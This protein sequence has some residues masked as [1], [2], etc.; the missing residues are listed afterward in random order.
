MNQ[1]DYDPDDIANAPGTGEFRSISGPI[2]LWKVESIGQTISEELETIQKNT[3]Y[4]LSDKIGLIRTRLAHIEKMKD[5][6]K[7]E[8]SDWTALAALEEAEALCKRHLKQ[9]NIEAPSEPATPQQQPQEGNQDGPRGVDETLNRYFDWQR[10]KSVLI[11][12][13]VLLPGEERYRLTGNIPHKD[14]AAIL[15]MA[16]R[17]EVQKNINGTKRTARDLLQRCFSGL[18]GSPLGRRFYDTDFRDP[19]GL[20]QIKVATTREFIQ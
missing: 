8:S 13:G 19:P 3:A 18:D 5:R 1:K 7:G 17:R 10:V 9:Y 6:F 4:S 11:E 14:V 15:H 20:E 16:A 12:R 2:R